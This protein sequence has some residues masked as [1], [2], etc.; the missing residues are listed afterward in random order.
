MSTSSTPDRSPSPSGSRLTPHAPDAPASGDRA[1][2]GGNDDAGYGGGN[3]VGSNTS[4]LESAASAQSG[5]SHGEG[6]GTGKSKSD[7]IG[8]AL[9]AERGDPAAGA[10]NDLS[11][12]PGTLGATSGGERA[13]AGSGDLNRSSRD[14]GN[15]L[16]D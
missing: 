16:D 15:S 12:G 4:G 5:T 1:D 6:T 13:A 3:L 2:N 11:S 8:S 9:A 7:P 10:G 14:H